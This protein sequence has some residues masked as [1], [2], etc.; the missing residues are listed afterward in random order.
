MTEEKIILTHPTLHF[1]STGRGK[2]HAIDAERNRYNTLCGQ[3]VIPGTQA[4]V[5]RQIARS[6]LCGNC[7]T[8]L[9]PYVKVGKV[10]IERPGEP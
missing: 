10:K 8:S 4:Q 1:I 7:Y 5:S 3:N 2:M 6:Q 9:Q